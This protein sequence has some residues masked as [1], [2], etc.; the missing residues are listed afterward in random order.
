MKN[1]SKRDDQSLKRIVLALFGLLAG[2]LGIV[3]GTIESA[4]TGSAVCKWGATALL[5]SAGAFSV[6]VSVFGKAHLVE[7]T[8]RSLRDGL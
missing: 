3:L 6:V 7:W 8:F 4:S 2:C 5:V 1:R